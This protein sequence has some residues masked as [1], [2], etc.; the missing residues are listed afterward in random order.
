MSPFFTL[1]PSFNKIADTIL[2]TM[3]PAGYDVREI[4]PFEEKTLISFSTR[5]LSPY[6]NRIRLMWFEM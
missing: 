6:V 3:K 5:E 2:K 1:S 4:E